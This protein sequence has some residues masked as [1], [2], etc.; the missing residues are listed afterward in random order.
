MTKELDLIA[1]DVGERHWEPGFQGLSSEQLQEKARLIAELWAKT[2]LDFTGITQ[3]FYE[4]D[5]SGKACVRLY[6]DQTLMRT[7]YANEALLEQILTYPIV[8]TNTPIPPPPRNPTLTIPLSP[9][10]FV[11][12]TS[13]PPETPRASTLQPQ[14]GSPRLTPLTP[15][16]SAPRRMSV[17]SLDQPL[18]ETPRSIGITVLPESSSLPETN[19]QP[20][21][22]LNTIAQLLKAYEEGLSK[23]KNLE[24]RVTAQQKQLANTEQRLNEQTSQRKQLE[25]TI[26]QQREKF[27][28]QLAEATKKHETATAPQTTPDDKRALHHKEQEI[29]QLEKRLEEASINYQAL[30]SHLAEVSSSL[31]TEQTQHDR[32]TYALAEKTTSLHQTT[33]HYKASMKKMHALSVEIHKLRRQVS[34]LRETTQKQTALSNQDLAT[35]Q[36]LEADKKRLMA[37]KEAIENR[38]KEA[39]QEKD[40]RQTDLQQVESHLKKLQ[41]TNAGLLTQIK[42]LREALQQAEEDNQFLRKKLKNKPTPVKEADQLKHKIDDLEIALAHTQAAMENATSSATASAA[43]NAVPAEQTA[44]AQDIQTLSRKEMINEIMSLAEDLLKEETETLEKRLSS[45]TDEQL[46]AQLAQASVAAQTAVVKAEEKAE[47]EIALNAAVGHETY[48]A[49]SASATND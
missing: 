9:R 39:A 46:A 30:E 4:K 28:R 12:S 31:K 32:T 25:D 45:F 3:R 48:T 21:D 11:P 15:V 35:I 16:A 41:E 24:A 14:P 19:E 29:A 42:Q 1:F 43:A 49:D 2:D 27:N 23:N 47:Q 37:E 20:D 34:E 13:S 5:Q 44:L 7:S 22:T 33:A 6:K 36:H 38:A 10:P 17:S 26:S 40:L 18:P 8:A